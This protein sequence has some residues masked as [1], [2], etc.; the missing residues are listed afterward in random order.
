MLNLKNKMAFVLILCTTFAQAQTIKTIK[1]KPSK[2]TVYLAGAELTHQESLN[3][4]TGMNEITLEGVSPYVDENSVSA[5]FKG[6]GIVIDTRKNIRYVEVNAVSTVLAERK[7]EQRISILNDSLD[8]LGFLL[9][10]AQNKFNALQKEESLLVNN[11][12]IRG[13]FAKDSLGLLKSALDLLRSRLMNIN[14]EELVQER[15]LA[16]YYKL[17]KSLKERKTNVEQ[18]LSNLTNLGV[19]N[20]PIYQL[21]VTISCEAAVSG[22]LFVKYYIANAGWVP[23][24]DINALSGKEKIDLTYRAQVY[25]NSGIDWKDINLKLSTSNPSFSNIKPTLNA[26]YLYF[27]SP[28]NSQ[29]KTYDRRGMPAPSISN[30]NTY[31]QYQYKLE[32]KSLKLKDKEDLTESNNSN[33][34]IGEVAPVFT[35][36]DNFFHAEYDIKTKYSIRSDNKAHHVIINTLDIPVML[37]YSSVPKLDKDAFLMGKIVNW[38]DLNLVPGNAKIY[39]D[40]SYLGQTI[41]DPT[42]TKDTLYL[43]LGRDNSI[44]IKRTILKEKCK[45]QTIG[46]HII[47]TKVVE[48]TIRNTKNI[49]LDFEIEDQVPITNDENIKISYTAEQKP[50]YNTYTGKLLWQMNLKSKD[51][52]KLQFTY[53]VKYPKDKYISGL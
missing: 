7:Y 5:I 14:E 51:T 49:N 2:A 13:E 10:D 1:T 30:N 17:Q 44:N 45:T 25:Q 28:Y 48:I 52:K 39:F 40:E 36:T 33:D 31:N 41:I 21:I 37:T 29:S 23:N 3:L 19:D 8:E 35:M 6:G 38:E 43:N 42:T 32:S 26:W 50:S 27:G 24:Y 22:N 11:R 16:M 34:D 12:L 47:V 46:D 9:K 4:T 18:L 20:N 15:R 53:E